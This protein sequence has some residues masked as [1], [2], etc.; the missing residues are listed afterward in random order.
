MTK[1]SIR[2][3]EAADPRRTMIRKSGYRLSLAASAEGS[4]RQIMLDQNERAGF[5]E[6]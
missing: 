5:D 6:N 4:G 1:R 3:Y 2:P